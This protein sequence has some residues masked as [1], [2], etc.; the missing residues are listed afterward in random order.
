MKKFAFLGNCQTIVYAKYFRDLLPDAKCKWVCSSVFEKNSWP[1]DQGLWGKD[2][3]EQSLFKKEEKQKYLNNCDIIV[4]NPIKE[5]TAT[6]YNYKLLKKIY[7]KKLLTISGFHENIHG[8]K[9]RESLYKIDIKISRI[10]EENPDKACMLNVNH[11]NTFCLLEA[12]RMICKNLNIAYFEEK[13]Y[14]ELL[15]LGYPFEK[16]TKSNKW[17]KL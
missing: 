17:T 13:K 14:S 12:V 4:C 7:N 6:L 5:E 10:L 1:K 2:C 9:K 11:P 15:E 16:K 8:I 3:V